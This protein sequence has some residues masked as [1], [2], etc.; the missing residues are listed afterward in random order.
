MAVNVGRAQHIVPDRTRT[1][2]EHRDQGCPVPGCDQRTVQV[3]HIIHWEDQGT[4]D[5]PNLVCLC[6][7]HHRMHH[8][9]R[10]GIEGNADEP[11]GLAFTDRHR[12]PLGRAGPAPPDL[13]P[14]WIAPPSN[15]TPPTGEPIHTQW[16]D[17]AHPQDWAV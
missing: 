16:V 15:W 5:T 14:D 2:V 9:G 7:G 6:R 3:H 8:Q 4:T 1:L 10:L 17:F 12:R 13:S 11:D